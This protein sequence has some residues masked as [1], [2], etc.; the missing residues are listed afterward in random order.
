MQVK[1]ICSALIQRQFRRGLV[2]IS[3]PPNHDGDSVLIYESA[4]SF[5]ALT[6]DKKTSFSNTRRME[7][8]H[9]ALST[10]W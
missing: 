1:G 10:V 8:V 6:L 4:F 9:G 5:Y 7:A 2:G 3:T